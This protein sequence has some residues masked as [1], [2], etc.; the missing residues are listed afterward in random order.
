MDQRNMISSMVFFLLAAIVLMTS[1]GLGIGLLN[2]PQAGFMPFW[3]SL[4]TILFSLILFGTTY[5]NRAVTVR[6]A[7]LWHKL[8]WQKNAMAIAVLTI[9]TLTL[10]S[11]GYLVSTSILMMILFY[12]G[13]LKVWVSALSSVLSVF[14]SYGLFQLLLKTPL[15]KGILGF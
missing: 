9:Y 7:D 4:F 10:P 11:V 1:M 5:R 12:L 8:H 14:F 15:P 2:N 3:A 6:I 13:G